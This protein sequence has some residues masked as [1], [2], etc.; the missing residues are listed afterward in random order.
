MFAGLAEQGEAVQL[1]KN[2]GLET[3]NDQQTLPLLAKRVW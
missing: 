2:A 1:T 3:S